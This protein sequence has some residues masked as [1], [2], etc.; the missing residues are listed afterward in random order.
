MHCNDPHNL[1][2]RKDHPDGSVGGYAWSVLE[3]NSNPDDAGSW[4]YHIS[5]CDIY[6]TTTSFDD[7]T[8]WVREHLKI[9][10]QDHL[11]L[12]RWYQN[13]GTMFLHEIF[14]LRFVWH[15]PVSGPDSPHSK[16]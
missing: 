3:D 15:S 11:S 6:Y 12:A 9:G 14:H 5:M 2:G 13:Q 7:T 10:R 8:K 1:C 16:F 4:T